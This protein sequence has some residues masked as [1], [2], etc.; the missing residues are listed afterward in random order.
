MARGI[1]EGQAL[2]G[3]AVDD[4]AVLPDA[5]LARK[6]AVVRVVLEQVGVRFHVE[7][8]IDRHDL[9]G[10]RVSGQD[11]LE[12]LPTDPA[13]TVDAKA[14][15]RDLLSIVIDAVFV[16]RHQIAAG[17]ERLVHA[18]VVQ[19]DR[20]QIGH[21]LEE[22]ELIVAEF[23]DPVRIDPQHADRLLFQHQRNDEDGFDPFRLG[24]RAVLEILRRLGILDP[25][26]SALENLAVEAALLD[27][28]RPL[29]DIPF[30]QTASP[31][32]APASGSRESRR[33]MLLALTPIALTTH[34]TIFSRTFD[35]SR[36]ALITLATSYSATK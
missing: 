20:A 30:G 28:Y 6:A 34:C 22:L 14:N 10:F 36:E 4:E 19:G 33:R 24:H 7:E 13:K 9:K 12:N 26:G 3:P 29:A 8:V 21:R 15:H 11:G 25:D 18:G 23:A 32:R 16:R 17:L 1:A 35:G 27:E 31:R 5:D 2:D